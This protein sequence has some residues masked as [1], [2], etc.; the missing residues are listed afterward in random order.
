MNALGSAGSPVP[1]S[2]TKPD[3]ATE[4]AALER[5]RHELAAAEGRDHGGHDGDASRGAREEQREAVAGRPS[6][7]EE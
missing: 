6:D 3:P 1:G 5:A 4:T 7:L 2:L